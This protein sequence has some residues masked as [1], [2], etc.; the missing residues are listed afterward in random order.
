MG[1]QGTKT[2]RNLHIAPAPHSWLR[3]PDDK[4][5]GQC[6]TIFGWLRPGSEQNARVDA[7]NLLRSSNLGKD[8]NSPEERLS[9]PGLLQS[10]FFK[11]VQTALYSS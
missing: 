7:S 2:P 3:P 6:P 9:S 5:S 4:D 10:Y 1:K 11:R 8:T